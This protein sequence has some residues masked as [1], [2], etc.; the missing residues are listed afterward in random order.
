MIVAVLTF[1]AGV[2][3]WHMFGSAVEGIEFDPDPGAAA[4]IGMLLAIPFIVGFV[5]LGL[6]FWAKTNPFGATLTALVIF[7][8]NILVSA[9][10]EPSTIVGGLILKIYI[11]FALVSGVRSG[12][13]FKRLS[14]AR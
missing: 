5:Y 7:L 10:I 8:T 1:I 14:R 6:Y 13:A 3:Q 11:G 12:L 2:L 4:Y 9:A